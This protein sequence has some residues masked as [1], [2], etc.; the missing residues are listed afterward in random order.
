MEKLHQG[1]CTGE[2]IS[3]LL[4]STESTCL[5]SPIAKNWVKFSIGGHTE[6]NS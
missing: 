1:Q 4:Y 2:T 3:L 6:T 5:K